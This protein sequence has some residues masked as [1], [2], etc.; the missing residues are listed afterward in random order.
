MIGNLEEIDPND[1]AAIFYQPN[2]DVDRLLADFAQDLA[3]R[4]VRVGGIVQR[5]FKGAN[6]T[7]AMCAVD[8]AT[9]QEISISKPLDSGTMSCTLDTNGLAEAAIVVSQALH[10]KVDLLVISKFGKQEAAGRGLRAEF[11]DA[12]TSGVPLLTAVPRKCLVDWRAF[13]GDVGT[14]L[15]CDRQVV[16]EWWRDSSTRLAR[17]PAFSPS[18]SY[19]A[20][21]IPDSLMT[22]VRLPGT[23]APKAPAGLPGRLRKTP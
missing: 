20:T 5:H 8:V 3:R 12:I 14:L 7:H 23:L 11:I 2:D 15:V 1:V 4:G 22:A 18:C 21:I 10:D 16:E 17:S 6:G 9:G 13:T 19:L